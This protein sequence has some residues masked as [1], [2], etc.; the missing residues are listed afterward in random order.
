MRVTRLV[1]LTAVATIVG[2]GIL[3]CSVTVAG[4]GTL[5]AGAPTPSLTDANSTPAP[6]TESP[7][8]T[9]TPSPTQDPVKTR[10]QVTCVLIQAAVKS[11]NDRFNAAKT[12]DAQ[13][14]I[15]RSGVTTVDGALKR[16]R[17]RGNNN[18]YILGATV[19]QELKK[20]VN[21]AVRGGSPST[22]P[23]NAATTK[24]RTACVNL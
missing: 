13:I 23:Y 22:T 9:P 16:S 3:G 10:E 19:L 6:P 21:S 8:P 12:R 15:L 11:T 18:I 5:A 14:T 4:R 20:L 7:T 17:L 1:T 2:S 24:F